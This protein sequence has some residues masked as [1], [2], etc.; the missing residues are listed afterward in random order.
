MKTATTPESDLQS[1]IETYEAI[2]ADLEAKHTGKWV[3]LK[4]RKLIDV[5]DSFETAAQ[6]A[7]RLYGRGP[8]L[9]RQVGAPP[10]ILPASLMYQMSG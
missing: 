7:V 1:E 8:Y 10:V 9:I 5:Y 6:N 4:D 2:Q 3:L